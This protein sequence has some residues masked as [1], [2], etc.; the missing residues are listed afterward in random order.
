ME[1]YLGRFK[2]WFDV[3][4]KRYTTLSE[5]KKALGW[6]WFDVGIKRYTTRPLDYT[7]NHKL[8]FDVG[9]KRYTTYIFVASSVTGCGLM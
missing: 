7:D 5:I 4:I 6:L 3:G 2:L 1:F 8:W 9:I